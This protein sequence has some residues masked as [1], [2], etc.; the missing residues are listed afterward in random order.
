M[1]KIIPRPVHAILD[2]AWSAAI[3]IAPRALGFEDE[4]NAARLCR[5]QGTLTT[6]GS[7]MTRYELGAIK[8]IPFRTHLK[9][10]A[11]S[12]AFGLASP[13]LL[14]FA[15]NKRARNAVL[16]F[17]IVEA[18]VVALSQTDEMKDEG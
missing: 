15:Q 6:L 18:I 17:F 3:A 12:A 8:I 1:L 14:G 10:D 2:Y 16:A 9:L 5:A 4:T 13:W 11:A 7:A